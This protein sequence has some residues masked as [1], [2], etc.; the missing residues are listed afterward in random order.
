MNQVKFALRS[1]GFLSLSVFMFSILFMAMYSAQVVY[2]DKYMEQSERKQPEIQTIDVARGSIL[3]RYGRVLVSNEVS[4]EARLEL[5]DLGT[6]V[7][8]EENLKTVLEIAKEEGVEWIDSL[9]ISQEAPYEYTVETIFQFNDVNSEGEGIVS[10]TRLARLGVIMEWF[11]DP[12]NAQTT[13]LPTAA[14]LLDMMA[15]SFEITETDPTLRREL[16]G[17]MYELFIRS[18]GVYWDSYIFSNDVGINF[19]VKV[20]EKK[21]PGIEVEPVTT[22]VLGTDY[23]AHLL[24]RV[25]SQSAAEWEYYKNLSGYEMNDLVGKEGAELAFEGYLRGTDGIQSIERNSNGDIT[26]SVW[27]TE[28]EPGGNVV[29]TLDI[30]LQKS[31]ED[32]LNYYV[33]RSLS[34]SVEGAA[35]VLMEVDSG[36]VLAAGSYPTFNLSTYSEDFVENTSNPLQPLVN[37]AFQGQYAPG[38]TFKMITAIA[39]LE[40]EVATPT[41]VHR[42]DGTYDF[43]EPNGPACWI[44]NQYRGSHGLV[45]V[46]DAITSSCNYYFYEVGRELGIDKVTAY[47]SHFGLGQ[48]SGI[49]LTESK[50]VMAGPEY[51][52]SMGGTWYAGATLSVVIGQESSQFTPLQLAN[53]I[54]AL[55]NGGTYYKAHLLSEVKSGDFSQVLYEYDPSDNSSDLQLQPQNV[56]A[57]HQGMI[58]LTQTGSVAEEFSRLRGMGI[59]V[60]AKTGTAQLTNVASDTANSVFVCFAPFENPEVSV[61]VVVERGGG[62]NDAAVIAAAVLEDYFT[63]R[64][65]RVEILKEN[66]FIP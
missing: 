40:E 9:N 55:A 63:N 53:Y 24:G 1:L 54:A 46:S 61:A 39:A 26:S 22:R 34:D 38:S 13:K 50:G 10:L 29:L 37:R 41:T 11:E 5:S 30:D 66:T 8:R 4:Y 58:E 52:E 27:S 48:S 57:I 49:E 65:S 17:V 56:A 16:I 21:I 62:S 31:V 3:D 60:G 43:Y 33:P 42:C 35:C 32:I 64:E 45:N 7:E 19:T 25:A 23:A 51:T 18:K 12:R 28:P 44:Y 36:S 20:K 2:G 47:A 15:E 14:E 6:G 59:S